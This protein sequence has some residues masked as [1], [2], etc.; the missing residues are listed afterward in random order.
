MFF[1]KDSF[2]RSA[3]LDFYVCRPNNQTIAPVI[4]YENDSMS[5]K[6]LDISELSFEVPEYIYL[7]QKKTTLLNPCFNY[8]SQYMRIKDSQG[9]I[10]RINSTLNGMTFKFNILLPYIQRLSGGNSNLA[11]N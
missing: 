6:L 11:F 1:N 10:F 8:L 2:K 5:L 9:R 3:P 4:G 7:P